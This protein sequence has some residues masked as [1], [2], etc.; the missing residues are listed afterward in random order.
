MGF[1]VGLMHS[2]VMRGLDPR[3]YHLCKINAKKMDPR[4][5]AGLDERRLKSTGNLHSAAFPKF[6]SYQAALSTPALA[7]ASSCR[8]VVMRRAAN[9]LRSRATRNPLA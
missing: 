6:A 5:T 4:V 9:Y 1:P 8:R 3:I 7:Q 2:V